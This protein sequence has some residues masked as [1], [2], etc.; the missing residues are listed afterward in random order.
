MTIEDIIKQAEERNAEEDYKEAFRLYS[1]AID[2]LQNDPDLYSA[3]GVVLFH[4]D[5][6]EDSLQ[7]MN[8]AVDLEPNYSYRYSSRAYIKASLRMTE[9][10]ILDYKKCTELDPEDAIAWN[11]M[12]LLEEQLGWNKKAEKTFKK[13]GSLENILKDKDIPK[14]KD[15]ELSKPKSEIPISK[16]KIIKDVFTKKETFKEFVK[17]VRSGFKIKNN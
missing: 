15:S 4:L 11:N 14:E 7:D 1:K 16:N 9:D 17:F 13:A 10:A 6:K 5:K 2:V 3:R 8:K 12:G